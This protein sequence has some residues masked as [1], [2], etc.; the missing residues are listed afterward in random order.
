MMMTIT[1]MADVT[2]SLTI[3]VLVF[4]GTDWVQSLLNLNILARNHPPQISDISDQKTF[5]SL[6]IG[7]IDFTITDADADTLT[8]GHLSFLS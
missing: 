5:E 8:L 6:T 2:G 7:P 4:D 1:P 3:T